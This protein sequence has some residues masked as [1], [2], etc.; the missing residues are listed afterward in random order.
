MS[1]S[2]PEWF[3]KESLVYSEER[4]LNSKTFRYPWPKSLTGP[5]HSVISQ[6]LFSD[7]YRITLQSRN[8]ACHVSQAYLSFCSVMEVPWL[9]CWSGL[10]EM[11]GEVMSRGQTD[12]LLDGVGAQAWKVSRQEHGTPLEIRL[13]ASVGDYFAK[14]GNAWRVYCFVLFS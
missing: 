12:R 6:S 1:Q 3:L 5:L 8:S 13:K 9:G 11:W 14:I 7:K 10:W 2:F 4:V